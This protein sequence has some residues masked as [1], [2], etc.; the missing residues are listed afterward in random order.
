[1][2]SSVK[3]KGLEIYSESRLWHPD[4]TSGEKG[5]QDPRKSRV[6]KSLIGG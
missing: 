2:G 3:G 4:E 1:M 5:S 6:L